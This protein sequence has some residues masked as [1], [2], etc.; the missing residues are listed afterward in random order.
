M[1]KYFVYSVCSMTPMSGSLHKSKK[2][3]TKTCRCWIYPI[4]EGKACNRNDNILWM[5]FWKIMT[6]YFGVN[7]CSTF[8]WVKRLLE[9]KYLGHSPVCLFLGRAHYNFS[10][11]VPKLVI[12]WIYIKGTFNTV[13]LF[14][15]RN[16]CVEVFQTL[17]YGLL[18]WLT[19]I[20]GL[21]VIV[22]V[23]MII[24]EEWIVWT[25]ECE[26]VRNGLGE[27]KLYIEKL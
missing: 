9:S 11:S 10:C 3:K 5:H 6:I 25:E 24:K 15:I 21:S 14:L 18:A 20:N 22:T 13:K 7:V 19:D 16:N 8:F 23:L 17:H 1:C 12:A 2:N 26:W 27:R 4:T